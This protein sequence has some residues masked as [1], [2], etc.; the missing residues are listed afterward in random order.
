MRKFIKIAV[1]TLLT[2]IIVA[3]IAAVLLVKF[4]DPNDF[5][6]QLTTQVQKATG[7]QVILAGPLSWK[8]LPRLGVE[9]RDVTIAS[10][11]GFKKPLAQVKLAAVETALLPLIF[12]NV[13]ISAVKLNGAKLHLQRN[14]KGIENWVMPVTDKPSKAPVTTTEESKSKQAKKD[15]FGSLQIQQVVIK[16]SEVT[17][18]N[19]KTG[20]TVKIQKFVFDGQDIE[21]GAIFPVSSRFEVLMTGAQKAI[22]VKLQ[23]RL[24]FDPAKADYALKDLKLSLGDT[25]ITGYFNSEGQAPMNVDF[26]FA[27]DE[28][29]VDQWMGDPSATSKAAAQTQAKEANTVVASKP[30]KAELIPVDFL[31]NLKGQGSL[32]IDNLIVQNMKF[33]N[34]KAAVTAKPGLLQFSPMSAE[35]YGGSVSSELNIDV[36]KDQPLLVVKEVGKN[37][38]AGPLFND[39]AGKKQ[40]SGTMSYGVNVT[41]R[42]QNMDE[43]LR[44]LNGVMNFVFEKGAVEGIDINFVSQMAVALFKRQAVP[45]KGNTGRTS[46]EKMSFTSTIRNGVLKTNDLMI[47]A[48]GMRVSADGTANLVNQKLDFDI[49]VNLTA[50]DADK[51]IQQLQRAAGGIP[52]T[53]EGT[54]TKY[55][56]KPDTTAITTAI[57][58]SFLESET[59]KF[60]EKFRGL[61]G[62]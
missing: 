55:H 43:W 24:T 2:I 61:F 9:A 53:L 59:G 28:L 30:S 56:L 40:L 58:K 33:K 10:A 5:K 20:K 27:I 42:G 38:K 39:W 50:L 25:D 13:R 22:P 23:A 29:N 34:L 18:Q 19:D 52:L 3:V 15:D 49:L 21:A 8:F 41:A 48:T 1:Y 7:Y 54:F 51:K 12:G 16:D 32:T 45:T 26:R 31:R 47:D 62:R 17:W 36:R 14:Q 46:F 35:G 4:V 57:G 44:S 6:T 37:I 60:N 11:P